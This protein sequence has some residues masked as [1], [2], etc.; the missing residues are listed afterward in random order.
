M[1]KTKKYKN[2]KKQNQHKVDKQEA[3]FKKKSFIGKV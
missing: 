3:K 2:V 1:K